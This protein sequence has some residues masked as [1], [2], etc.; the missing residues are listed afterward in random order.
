[1]MGNRGGDGKVVSK[2]EIP[3]LALFEWFDD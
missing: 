2:D 3:A 1:V